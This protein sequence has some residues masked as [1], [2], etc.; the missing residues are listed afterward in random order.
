MILLSIY[1]VIFIELFLDDD[2]NI[3]DEVMSDVW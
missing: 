3:M 1:L 2:D